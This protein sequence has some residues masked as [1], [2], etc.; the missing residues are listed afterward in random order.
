MPR[1]PNLRPAAKCVRLGEDL[2]TRIE[3]DNP[4]QKLDKDT[5]KAKAG[6][7]LPTIRQPKLRLA[8]DEC[9]PGAFFFFAAAPSLHAL[10][11]QT[12]LSGV[13]LRVHAT[14]MY[15]ER[16]GIEAKE[17]ALS[18]C[19]ALEEDKWDERPWGGLPDHFRH[20]ATHIDGKV[21]LLRTPHQKQW[22]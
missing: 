12:P 18:V 11:S 15:K 6:R 22:L 3:I 4:N 7:D 16:C 19:R 9:T 20:L 8:P 14:I 1:D 10:R 13:D 2:A 5:C 21:V 17:S